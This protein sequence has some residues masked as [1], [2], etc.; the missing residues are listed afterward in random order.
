MAI[1]R[2]PL[3][4]LAAIL[5][6][7]TN[8]PLEDLSFFSWVGAFEQPTAALRARNRQAVNTMLVSRTFKSLMDTLCKEW[9]LLSKP[10]DADTLVSD[11]KLLK[12]AKYIFIGEPG[13]AWPLLLRILRE[14]PN[15]RGLHDTRRVHGIGQLPRTSIVHL[16]ATPQLAYSLPGALARLVFLELVDGPRASP[17]VLLAQALPCLVS[18]KIPADDRTVL[19]CSM[20]ALRNLCIGTSRSGRTRSFEFLLAHGANL[21]Q[22][23]FTPF[24]VPPSMTNPGLEI[25]C[26][27]LVE[28]VVDA[29]GDMV[30]DDPLWSRSLFGGRPR[31]SRVLDIGIRNL[32]ER[33]WSAGDYVEQLVDKTLF[34]ALK[35]VRDLG[36]RSGQ[37]GLEWWVIQ[38]VCAQR[39]VVLTD[40]AGNRR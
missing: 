5:N 34:P 17:P 24:F 14:C 37:E 38:R 3:E 35:T 12:R 23:E 29:H 19:R 40:A 39:G 27:R 7:A 6:S 9:V 26:P 22:L 11:E 33:S 21:R 10:V 32:A 8:T 1:N 20:P 31:H 13:P 28:L 4:T 15:L 16:S 30:W 2:I 18:L 36:Y 25:L